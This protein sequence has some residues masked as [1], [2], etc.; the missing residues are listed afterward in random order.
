M[1]EFL[2]GYTKMTRKAVLVGI[3]YPNTKHELK[4][5]INDVTAMKSLLLNKFEFKLENIDLIINE[6][7]TTANIKFHLQKMVNSSEPG[8]LLFF[9]FSGHGTQMYSLNKDDEPDGLDECIC[10]VDIDWKTNIIRDNDLRQIFDDVPQDVQFVVLMDCCN[11]GDGLDQ[12]NHYEPHIV[13]P[14]GFETPVVFKSVS[15]YMTPPQD[16]AQQPPISTTQPPNKIIEAINDRG[17]LISGC[18]SDQTS[19]DAFIDGKYNGACTYH[20]MSV[21]KDYDY[22]ICYSKLIDELSQRLYDNGFTQNPQLN[23]PQHLFD[24]TFIKHTQSK[25]NQQIKVTKPNFW[26]IINQWFKNFFKMRN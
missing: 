4:G 10:P 6:L 25:S 16:I 8:D 14:R 11:S 19:A 17:V 5:C 23:G 1:C 3:N 9:H 22:D 12:Q 7:A 21:L 2:V 26:C 18:N 20:L 24:T 13:K 15:R